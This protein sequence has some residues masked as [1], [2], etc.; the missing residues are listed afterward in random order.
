MFGSVVKAEQD[1]AKTD[2]GFL[3]YG[4]LELYNSSSSIKINLDATEN[5][6]AIQVN[7]KSKND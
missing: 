3:D 4:S 2:I 6:K 5:M 7:W 1:W